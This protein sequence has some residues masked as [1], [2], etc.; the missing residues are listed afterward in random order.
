MAARPTRS[1]LAANAGVG[2]V[3]G[4]HGEQ[5]GV[6][7]ERLAAQRLAPGGVAAPG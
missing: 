5:L 3:G 2:A 7:G 4:I 6:A 1:V